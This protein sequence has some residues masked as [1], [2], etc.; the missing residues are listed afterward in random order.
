MAHRFGKKA[1]S[2]DVTGLS[3]EGAPNSLSLPITKFSYVSSA[4][5]Q[6]KSA[7]APELEALIPGCRLHGAGS[8][9][10]LGRE[11]QAEAV[12]IEVNHWRGEQ[13]QHLADK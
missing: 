8:K 7:F 13:R 10:R 12:K 9:L 2:V 6:C 4:V 3:S 1:A 5:T 11:A